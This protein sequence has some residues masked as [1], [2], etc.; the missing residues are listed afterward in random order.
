MDSVP[1]YVFPVMFIEQEQEARTDFLRKQARARVE[2]V[3]VDDL[4]EHVVDVDQP[5]TSAG[6]DEET[7]LKHV[8]IFEDAEQGVCKFFCQVKLCTVLLAIYCFA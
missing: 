7:P 1:T 6:G 5:G 2:G 8:N 3:K 4:V